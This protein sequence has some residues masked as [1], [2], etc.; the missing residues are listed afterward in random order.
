MWPTGWPQ[1]LRHGPTHSPL[2]PR[3]ELVRSADGKPSTQ[4]VPCENDLDPEH[5][6]RH[7]DHNVS[8]AEGHPLTGVVVVVH[9]SDDGISKELTRLLRHGHPRYFSL[10]DEFG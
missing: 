9:Y 10:M 4:A 5:Q 7:L 2:A 3:N 1:G 6:V 8:Q